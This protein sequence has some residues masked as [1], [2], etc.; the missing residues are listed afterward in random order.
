MARIEFTEEQEKALV[1]YLTKLIVR[2]SCASCK[3]EEG[4]FYP[5]SKTCENC[6]SCSNWK[7]SKFYRDK[8]LR[9]IE[10][11]KMNKM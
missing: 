2:K 5:F 3:S 9:E 1:K 10:V 11:I 8:V 7:P 6:V 4:S